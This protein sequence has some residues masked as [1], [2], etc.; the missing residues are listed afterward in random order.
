MIS[1]EHLE[2]AHDLTPFE[3]GRR[4]VDPLSRIGPTPGKPAGESAGDDLC[5]HPQAG[6]FTLPA[7]K[8]ALCGYVRA[9]GLSPRGNQNYRKGSDSYSVQFAHAVQLCGKTI[10]GKLMPTWLRP[11]VNAILGKVP[12]KTSRL[13]MATRMT[14]DADF[15]LRRESPRETP[16]TVIRTPVHKRGLKDQK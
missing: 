12:G 11:L 9:I 1:Q 14:I 2:G 7:F 15:S 16:S 4:T 6:V 8:Q 3:I 5:D 10:E 13:D